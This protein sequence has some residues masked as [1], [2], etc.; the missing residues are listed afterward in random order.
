M[1]GLVGNFVRA[2][3][4]ESSF[5]RWAAWSVPGDCSTLQRTGS[6][7]RRS[8]FSREPLDAVRSPGQF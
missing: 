6:G 1:Q 8:R 3:I 7:E 5:V 2:G 4:I